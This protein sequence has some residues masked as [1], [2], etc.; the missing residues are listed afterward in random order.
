MTIAVSAVVN[1]SRWLSGAVTGMCI[2]VVLIGCLVAAGLVGE[3]AKVERIAIATI[4][5]VVAAFVFY[6]TLSAMKTVVIH[7]SG[8]GQIRLASDAD[9]KM[10]SENFQAELQGDEGEIVYLRSASTLWTWLLI[11]HLQHENGRTS[12]MIILPDSVSA[13]AFRAL[14]VACR[15]IAMRHAEE[16][17]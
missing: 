2:C 12:I 4:C 13:D 9:S 8:T 17:R 5:M 6:R 14:L 11:L 7:V 1:R 3:L 15:W 10:S 16:V